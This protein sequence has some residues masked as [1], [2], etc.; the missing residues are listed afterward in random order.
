[1][2]MT[3]SYYNELLKELEMRKAIRAQSVKAEANEWR[4]LMRQADSESAKGK[5]AKDQ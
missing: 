1:M 2:K 4:E 5:E 3:R